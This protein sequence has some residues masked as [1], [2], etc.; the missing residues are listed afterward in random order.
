MLVES[1]GFWIKRG[2]L[3]C[4]ISDSKCHE[5]WNECASSMNQFYSPTWNI[6]THNPNKL[7]TANAGLFPFDCM[8]VFILSLFNLR[9]NHCLY[10]EFLRKKNSSIKKSYMST[11]MYQISHHM[12]PSLDME[13]CKALVSAIPITLITSSG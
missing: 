9:A 4:G 10:F 5:H 7:T 11:F 13:N 6:F 12:L 2:A 8:Y 1:S 3:C